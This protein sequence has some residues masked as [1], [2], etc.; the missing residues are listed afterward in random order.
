MP[1]ALS[2]AAAIELLFKESTQAWLLSAIHTPCIHPASVT[3][4]FE[5]PDRTSLPCPFKYVVMGLL[6]MHISNDFLSLLML[7]A[8]TAPSDSWLQ[9]LDPHQ[10]KKCFLLCVHH[11]FA[12]S[13][14]APTS[15]SV[16][17]GQQP[18]PSITVNLHRAE[19]WSGN[20]LKQNVSSSQVF[21]H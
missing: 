20:L 16:G 4:G 8:C 17:F 6:P 12:S 21:I 2:P 13:S 7:S 3:V 5:I 15:C 9:Q 11:S 18:Q 1:R 10:V 19:P 14:G